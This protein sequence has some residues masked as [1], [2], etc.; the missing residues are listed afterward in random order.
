[1]SVQL[2]RPE[3]KCFD[4][5]MRLPFQ[6]V[7]RRLRELLGAGL[8][9]Y[10]GS[11]RETRA[12]RQWGQGRRPGK[13]VETRLRHAY[14]IAQCIADSDGTETAQ[15]WFQ[16][17]N[18]MLDDVSP[19]RLLRGR[20]GGRRSGRSYGAAAVPGQ[21]VSRLF[22]TRSAPDLLFRVGRCPDVWTWTDWAYAGENGTFGGRW[23]DPLGTYRVLYTSGS[24]VGAYLE[25]LAEYRPDLKVVE[26]L[27]EIEENDAEAPQTL[28]AGRL[29]GR[30]RVQRIIGKGLSDGVKSPLVDVGSTRSL[31]TL[32][33][34]LA[35]EALLLGV[36]DVDA[37]SIRESVDRRFTQVV[38][39]TVYEQ[40]A[41]YAGV[42]YL[43][44][45]GND[46]ADYAIFERSESPQFPIT[47]VERSVIELDDEDFQRACTLH[48][49]TPS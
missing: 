20:P 21:R 9:A 36:R 12:V 47:H 32:R 15:A 38:S 26:G 37:A 6:E 29:P 48:G 27:E 7:A 16:G 31:A 11:V 34:S 13:D 3:L 43:S 4:D 8:V 22:T 17:L 1:M 19:A 30:W 2:P 44:R 45:Y 25:A 18:P 35:A 49:I 14:A 10:I 28:P 33:K 24:R 42:F 46:V 23:D 40:P 39:R 41:L 5:A